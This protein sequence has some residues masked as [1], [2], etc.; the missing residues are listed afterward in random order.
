MCFQLETVMNPNDLQFMNG[1]IRIYD[2]DKNLIEKINIPF[3]P[4]INQLSAAINTIDIIKTFRWNKSSCS[5]EFPEQSLN[6]NLILSALKSDQYGI[7]IGLDLHLKWKSPPKPSDIGKIMTA[8]EQE[9]E[10]DAKMKENIG[11]N[12]RWVLPE[13]DVNMEDNLPPL[14]GKDLKERVKR[15]ITKLKRKDHKIIW[16]LLGFFFFFCFLFAFFFQ[17]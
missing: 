9:S 3:K 17:N 2:D 13:L 10:E 8:F 15:I 12:E 1:W 6:E 5:L 16:V 14:T 7:T 11:D 4:S